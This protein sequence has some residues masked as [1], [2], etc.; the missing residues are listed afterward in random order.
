[1][2]GEQEPHAV[3]RR[4]AASLFMVTVCPIFGRRITRGE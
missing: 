1:M 3:A 4:S 2:A